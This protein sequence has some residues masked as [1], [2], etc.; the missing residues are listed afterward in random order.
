MDLNELIRIITNFYHAHTGVAICLLVGLGILMIVKPK[1]VL[2][3]LGVI[4]G[5]IVAAYILY[6]LYDALF[7]GMTGKKELFLKSP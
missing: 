6:L 4:A 3:T 7:S 1:P 5:L 2:K